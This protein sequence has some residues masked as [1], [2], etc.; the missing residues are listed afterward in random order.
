MPP[1][2]TLLADEDSTADRAPRGNDPIKR[3][4]TVSVYA[5]TMVNISDPDKYARYSALAT[6][7]NRIHGGRFLVR[8]GNPETV[9]GSL[10]FARVVVNEFA[11]RGQ[12]RAFYGSMEYQKAKAER[13]GAADFNMI[14]VD[15]V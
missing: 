7:A 5:I 1:S 2:R 10:P 11:T 13:L 6:E 14:I 12:A 9:E 3:S 8:G 15:G 4:N